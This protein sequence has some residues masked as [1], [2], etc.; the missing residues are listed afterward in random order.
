[1]PRKQGR[2]AEKIGKRENT[3]VSANRAAAI[4][5]DGSQSLARA[6][7]A[8]SLLSAYAGTAGRPQSHHATA[9]KL[10]KIVYNMLDMANR[11]STLGGLLREAIPSESLKNLARRVPVRPFTD[12]G[13]RRLNGPGDVG[14]VPWEQSPTPFHQATLIVTRMRLGRIEG[15]KKM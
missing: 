9:H 3:P 14:V 7:C 2:L 8:G 15:E 13:C 5:R 10:A 1:M 6:D 11:M 4:L 12:S